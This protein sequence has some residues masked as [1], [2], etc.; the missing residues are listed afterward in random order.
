MEE[1]SYC[2]FLTWSLHFEYDNC[3]CVQVCVRLGMSCSFLG[4][5]TLSVGSTLLHL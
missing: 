3:V 1:N 5:Y 2:E 4:L